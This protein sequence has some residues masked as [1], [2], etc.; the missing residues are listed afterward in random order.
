MII[1]L[2]LA[3]ASS[4]SAQVPADL[5]QAFSAASE[6]AAIHAKSVKPVLVV[7]P[8]V[9]VAGVPVNSCADAKSLEIPFELTITLG[10]GRTIEQR[11]SYQGCEEEGRNDY[12]PPYTTRS[13]KGTDGYALTIVT[14]EG[15]DASSVLLS[16][17]KDWV[18]RFGDIE[19]AKLVSGDELA[20]GG[21]DLKN[22]KGKA[23]LRGASA[24]LY[25]QLKQCEVSITKELGVAL[26]D[27]SNRP[28]RG[29][30]AG[31]PALVLLTDKTAYYYHQ[32]CDICAEVT[33]CELATG[34]VKSTIAAHQ[35]DCSDMAPYSKNAAYDACA[36]QR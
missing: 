10:N 21:V 30:E 1:S 9:V 17:G 36:P 33:Q 19:N 18:G 4:A 6:R 26:R 16:L 23:V 28:Y 3:V 14:D 20:A 7:K 32:D 35:V 22:A 13:Y 34:A 27:L 15:K 25:P 29:Y 8:E 31:R 12:L 5:Y 11:F 24:P 2:L